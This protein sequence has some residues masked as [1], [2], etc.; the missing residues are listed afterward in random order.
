MKNK[1]S[2]FADIAEQQK[3]AERVEIISDG[4]FSAFKSGK[5]VRVNGV[6]YSF[7][8][9]VRDYE[10]D[11]ALLHGFMRGDTESLEDDM[12]EK[13]YAYCEALAAME[14]KVS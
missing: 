12:T 10:I 2:A 13:L 1:T 8:D 4:F 3:I 11:P 6:I 7:D 9:F 5:V 14:V